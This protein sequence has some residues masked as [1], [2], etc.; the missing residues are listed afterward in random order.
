MNY[1]YYN[2]EILTVITIKMYAVLRSIKICNF[3]MPKAA[4]LTILQVLF[5]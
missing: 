4:K 2:I 1:D 5:D 3:K